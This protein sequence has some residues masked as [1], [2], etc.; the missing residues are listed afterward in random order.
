MNE[1][2][3]GWGHMLKSH[4]VV[5]LMWAYMLLVAY[6]MRSYYLD[7]AYIGFR[8]IHNLTAGNGLVFNLG[9]RV[10][11]VTNVGWL[12]A[13]TPLSYCLAIPVAGKVAGAVLVMATGALSYAIALRV[14]D[15]KLG[16][17]FALPVP[18][19]IATHF[20]YMFFSLAGMETAM[21]STLL[22]TV[23]YLALAERGRTVSALLCSFGFLLHPECLLIY[24]VFELVNVKRIIA[25]PRKRLV[26]ILVFSAAIVMFT[27]ARYL[28]YSDVVPN[29][30]H[31]KPTRPL[32]LIGHIHQ[33]LAASSTNIPAPF[34]GL[35]VLPFL[36]YG[37]MV[38]WRQRPAGA[39]MMATIVGVGLAFSTYARVDWTHT[40]R[41]FAPYVPLAFVILWTGLVAAHRRL[42]ESSIG[43]KG[44]TGLVMAYAVLI[45]FLGSLSMSVHLCAEYA[46]TYPGY[47]MTSKSLVQ[48][49]IWMGQNLPQ[50]CVI[51]TR[52]IGAI[53][54]YSKRNILDYKFG[55][56]N[57]ELAR[58]VLV[59]G[60]G[61]DDPNDPALR[62]VWRRLAPD[63]F[64]EDL[65]NIESNLKPRGQRPDEF[66]I[67]GMRYHLIKTFPI[68]K[69]VDWA[70]CERTGVR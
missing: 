59:H 26:P 29:T 12:L 57:T 13:L 48:P 8:Y 31:S 1:T 37:I 66:D 56:T 6:Q 55:L 21:L 38:I 19:F 68:G 58:L 23:A 44:M 20:D 63:Y 43:E 67:H 47:V 53:A 51:A 10:E 22:C 15:P 25:R 16:R 3:S 62:D 39:A 34:A 45:A 24:P 69:D 49:S 61:F 52:R 46:E 42:F 60:E 40:G 7:D 64:L 18:V 28:Y 54:Y 36:A 32:E 41:Y 50:D 14:A 27:L 70:L 2:S 35:L 9:E 5:P 65:S 11:G 30:F 17:L 33:S 4:M